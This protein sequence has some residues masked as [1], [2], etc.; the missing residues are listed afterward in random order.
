MMIFELGY[1]RLGY[2]RLRPVVDFCN[3]VMTA[4]VIDNFSVSGTL[5]DSYTADQNISFCCRIHCMFTNHTNS[6]TLFASLHK[7]YKEYA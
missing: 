2:V 1:V 4:Y 6:L 7:V 5:V 3:D